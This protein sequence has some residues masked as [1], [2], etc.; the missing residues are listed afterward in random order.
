MYFDKNNNN[1]NNRS[2]RT[3]DNKSRLLFFEVSHNFRI[4]MT[5]SSPSHESQ[6]KMLMYNVQH[7][8]LL[9]I[10]LMSYRWYNS[11]C[12]YS[13]TSRCFHQYRCVFCIF[14]FR[15]WYQASIKSVYE[16]RLFF[17]RKCD[18]SRSQYQWLDFVHRFWS[19]YM[20]HVKFYR[21]SNKLI[22]DCVCILYYIYF[23]SIW[24]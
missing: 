15:F 11:S 5:L 12:L 1:H 4:L 23:L 18:K 9:T 14:S 16:N 13:D 3:R 21:I 6:L 2:I 10:F 24:E 17:V 19:L 8:G 20:V 22:V 7:A